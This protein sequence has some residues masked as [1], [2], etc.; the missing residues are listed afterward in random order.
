MTSEL[1]HHHRVNIAALLIVLMSTSC[2]AKKEQ[3]SVAPQETDKPVNVLFILSDDHRYDLIGKY[4]P[5]IQTPNLDQLANKGTVFKN[6]FVTTPICASSR[7]SILSGLTERTHDF[8]FRQPKAG[9]IESANMYPNIVK[10]GGYQTSFVGKYEIGISG[11]NNE[12]F[13]Y[14]K[15]LLQ[16]KTQSYEGKVLPQSYYIAELAN[17]FIEQSSG[18]GKPW[19]MAVNFWDP[20]AH[21]KDKIDQYH[22]PEEFESM[23]QNVS[24]PAAKLS[25]DAS[26][27]ALPE[28]LKS[29]IGRVRWEYRYA[30]EQ[31]YQ[32]MVK[33]YYRAISAVDKAVGMIYEKLEQTG[34]ADN[35]VVIYMSDNGYN[36]NERQL[37]GKWFGWEESLRVPLIIYDPRKQQSH[38]KEVQEMALN[39]DIASTIV[40]LVGVQAPSSYQGR[41]LVPL[42]DDKN[43]LT[44]REEFFFEHMYQP[45]RV[46]IPPTVGLRTERWKYVDFYKNDYQQLYDLQNDPKEKTNLIDSPEHQRIVSMLSRRV[47]DYIQQYE[48]QRSDEVRQRESFVNT[49]D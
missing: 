24:I 11:D 35:T 36:V 4:H 1:L 49:R 23:Y 20:H 15:P 16:S 48:Q 25:D 14:F 9:K 5:I 27:E 46:S 3:S 21:D 17:D 28:F 42:L 43:D 41:S 18:S 40:D 19:V 12:R 13:D 2:S 45:K 7:V 44:W 29:S 30:N 39:I 8:T 31:M 37:A 38:G 32:K 33:R 34:V 6:A 47:D 26:F 22:Y 10:Q